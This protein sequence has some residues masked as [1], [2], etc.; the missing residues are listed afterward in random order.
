MSN[1]D[2]ITTYRQPSLEGLLPLPTTHKSSD[3]FSTFI[4]TTYLI[5]YVSIDDR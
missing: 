2:Y 1:G 5:V 3:A 4:N